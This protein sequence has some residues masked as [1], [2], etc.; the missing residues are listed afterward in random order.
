MVTVGILGRFQCWLGCVC[1]GS[2]MVHA[3]SGGARV[4]SGEDCGQIRIVLSEAV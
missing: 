4:P 1:V 3:V 2:V